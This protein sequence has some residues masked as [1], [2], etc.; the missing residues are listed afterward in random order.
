MA[1]DPDTLLIFKMRGMSPG[2]VQ[3]QGGGAPIMEY[4]EPQPAGGAAGKSAEAPKVEQSSIYYKAGAEYPDPIK[5]YKEAIREEKEVVIQTA[6]RGRSAS[7]AMAKEFSCVAHPFRQAYAICAYCHRPF[8]FEDIIEFQKDY[9][10]I[11]DIDRVTEHHQERL[12]S[13]YSA[14]SLITSFILTACFVLFLYYSHDQLMYII[15]LIAANPVGF[16]GTVSLAY[17]VSLASLVVAVLGLGAAVYILLGSRQSHVMASALS[18]M[19]VML[20]TYQYVSTGT[21]YLAIITVLEFGAFLA[22]VHSAASGAVV[23]NRVR[24]SAADYALSYGY[25]G[26]Y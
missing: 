22:A 17:A 15:G 13:E 18:I 7:R 10:C 20:F 9:Y 3:Q 23:Y 14:S 19:A 24:D 1:S 25:G 12:T 21:E 11:E 2:S 16:A 8:C 26:R 4:H 6:P 5:Y